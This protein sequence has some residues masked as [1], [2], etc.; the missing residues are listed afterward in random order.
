M[1]GP[2]RTGERHRAA[3]F[4]YL[5]LLIAVAVLAGATA[6]GTQAGAALARQGAEAQLLTVGQAFSRALDSYAQATPLGQPTAPRDLAELLRDPRYPQP[7]RHLRRLFDDPLTGQPTWGLLRDPQGLIVGVHSLAPGEPIKQAGF[8][9]EQAHLHEA[10]SYA[11]W[12]FQR[13]QVPPSGNPPGAMP[14]PS[15]IQPPVQRAF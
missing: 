14:P 1:D 15:P 3:G 4:A 13:T 11:D 7:M 10:K 8:E 5:F 2:M 6:W 12:V 9:P